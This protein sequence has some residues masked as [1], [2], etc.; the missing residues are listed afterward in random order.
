MT[1]F[2]IILGIVLTGAIV[3]R[4][5]IFQNQLR[6]LSTRRST[7]GD[8]E[9][10]LKWI[11]HVG[12]ISDPRLTHLYRSQLKDSQFEHIDCIREL[13][14]DQFYSRPNFLLAV[15]LVKS[16]PWLVKRILEVAYDAR[17]RWQDDN[18]IMT[19]LREAVRD[20]YNNLEKFDLKGALA[21]KSVD[22]MGSWIEMSYCL[23]YLGDGRYLKEWNGLLSNKTE[24][25]DLNLFGHVP[26]KP[27]PARVCDHCLILLLIKHGADHS[28]VMSEYDGGRV[29]ASGLQLKEVNNAVFDAAIKD[30]DAIAKRYFK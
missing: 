6:V 13:C 28:R 2:S 18:E 1:A 14:S 29:F 16:R 3:P 5:I 25:N 4:E 11:C 7:A 27:V 22:Y 21:G 19:V 10:A 24:L 20:Y 23:A 15:N 17:P 30:I 12:M 8:R 9:L 26:S